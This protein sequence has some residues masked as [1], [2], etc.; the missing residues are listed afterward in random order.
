MD[1]D[2]DLSGLRT[3][4]DAEGADAYLIHA[5]GADADQ[6]YVSGF[7]A[8]DPFQTLVTADGVH[9]LVSG[10]EYGRARTKARADS[11]TNT[12]TYDAQH[13]FTE[14]G[15]F[16]GQARIIAAFLAEYDIETVA[17][18]VDFPAGLATLLNGVGISVEIDTEGAVQAL[19]AVKTDAEVDAIRAAQRSNERAMEVA[20]T[21][22]AAADVK[23]G[24]LHHD[25]EPLTSERIKTEIEITL[26]R[27]GCGLDEAIVACGADAADPHDRG[28]GP[29]RA[30]ESI[31]VDIFPFDKETKY[32]ADM[33]RT[34]VK[35]TPS[36]ELQ[37]RYDV[38]EVAYE[39]ALEAIEAGV[40]GEDV[41]VAASEVIEDAGYDTLRSNPEAETG[42]IHGTGHGVGLEIH[43]RPSVSVAGQPLEA[44]HVITIE[45]GLYDPEIGGIRIEDLVVVTDDGYENLTEYPVSI[46]PEARE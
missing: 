29:L 9:L 27:E 8:P 6:R 13:L 12:A 43:E 17:V 3:Y 39:A 11:V 20:E 26:L 19:R 7:G 45:P 24:V 42:F 10:L 31:V 34:F 44:G 36:A 4:L 5:D 33:T 35:G 23:D 41:H 18:P 15:P 32:Y 25:G 46:E 14:Y 28:S 38:V 37:K 22:I 1:H 40:T 2:V 30:D 16:E 21:M